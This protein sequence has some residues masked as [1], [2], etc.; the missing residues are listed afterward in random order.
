MVFCITFQFTSSVQGGV[1]NAPANFTTIEHLAGNFLRAVP[2]KPSMR[3]KRHLTAWDQDFLYKA[4][5]A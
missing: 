1:V 2:G 3:V 4:I 5:T